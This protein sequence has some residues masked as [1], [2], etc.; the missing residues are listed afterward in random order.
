MLNFNRLLNVFWLCYCMIIPILWQCSDKFKV[1]CS[2]VGITISPVVI[3]FI[4]LAN[5]AA[6]QLSGKYISLNVAMEQH[7]A[8]LGRAVNELTETNYALG[9]M[10]LAALLLVSSERV[11]GARHIVDEF[12]T[13]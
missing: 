2:Y 10:M 6:M 13:R 1:A 12:E 8:I 11:F 5:Y 9:F 7:Q 4:F 3:S